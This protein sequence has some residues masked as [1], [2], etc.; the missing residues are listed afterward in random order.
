MP[1]TLSSPVHELTLRTNHDEQTA[2][3]VWF[4]FYMVSEPRPWALNVCAVEDIVVHRRSAQFCER[5]AV[6]VRV[7]VG[8]GVARGC[9][10]MWNGK[11]TILETGFGPC[12]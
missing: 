12:S 10:E 9:L 2:L 4:G 8:V 3:V 5:E 6:G 7:G 1:G 11:P